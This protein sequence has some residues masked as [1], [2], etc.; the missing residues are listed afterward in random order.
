MATPTKIADKIITTTAPSSKEEYLPPP[1]MIEETAPPV[2]EENKTE[3]SPA[4][5]EGIQWDYSKLLDGGTLG[6]L[7]KNLHHGIAVGTDW[8]GWELNDD[9]TAQYDKVLG[10][11]LE[12]LLAKIEY[13]PLVLGVLALVSIEGMKIGNYFKFDRDRKKLAEPKTNVA[14]TPSNNATPTVPP[15]EVIQPAFPSQSVSGETL[16]PSIYDNMPPPDLGLPGSGPR[17]L[18]ADLPPPPK[19]T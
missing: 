17:N 15:N 5:K 12:P 4:V 1:G 8:N 9:E 14:P 6:S 11:I 16:K 7:S 19:R 3:T 2:N 18:D 13:L 10:M